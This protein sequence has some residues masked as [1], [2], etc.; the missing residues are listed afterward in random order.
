MTLKHPTRRRFIQISAACSGAFLL[1]GMAG[2]GAMRHDAAANA[3]SLETST[4]TWTGTAL[5]ADASLQVIHP[6]AAF[7]QELIE[8]CIAEVQR[9][10]SLFSLY[11]DDS[12]LITLNRQGYLDAPA[13]DFLTLLNRSTEFSRLTDGMFDAT[14]QPLWEA[15]ANYFSDDA[16]VAS[17]ENARYKTDASN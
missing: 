6:D 5:G 16:V 1:T 13:S 15:Y 2:L 3:G 14:V 11:R 8:R 12:A 10:E 4:H 17:A 7:A 9:L